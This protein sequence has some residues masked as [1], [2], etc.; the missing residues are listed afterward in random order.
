MCLFSVRAHTHTH[1]NQEFYDTDPKLIVT[2]VKCGQNH[3]LSQPDLQRQICHKVCT[4]LI[5][6]W[7]SQYYLSATGRGALKGRY[8]PCDTAAKPTSSSS[9]SFP[10][11][12]SPCLLQD[13]WAGCESATIQGFHR[14]T[15]RQKSIQNWNKNLFFFILV[16]HSLKYHD[17]V[18]TFSNL[19]ENLNTTRTQRFSFKEPNLSLILP[20]KP[21]FPPVTNK[22]IWGWIYFYTMMV[23]PYSLNIVFRNSETENWIKPALFPTHCLQQVLLGQTW[24]S[25][26][27]WAHR[28]I[29]CVRNNT[30]EE[31]L[32]NTQGCL[33]NRL[34][35]S[36]PIPFGWKWPS[37]T[38]LHSHS[39]PH[40]RLRIWWES[41]RRDS[42]I[43]V[44]FTHKD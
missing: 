24:G 31:K 5:T 26:T 38:F 30:A 39:P 12:S 18:F 13:L 6:Y 29:P 4:F 8:L 28:L 2:S 35:V 32:T 43:I 42:E 3:F 37:E 11:E 36:R 17:F 44:Y 21:N 41:S 7:V 27:G 23:K 22:N 14:L 10:T 16:V 19:I 9:P 1:R 33:C 15:A 34:T 25:M 40:K 20:R